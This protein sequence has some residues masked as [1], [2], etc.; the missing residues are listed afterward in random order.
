MGLVLLRDKSGIDAFGEVLFNC[1]Y[2]QLY[3][4]EVCL[5]C[6]ELGRSS[7]YL[8]SFSLSLHLSFGVD[9]GYQDGI[10]TN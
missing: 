1:F 8:Y 6:V 2:F 5:G 10:Q 4:A 3:L 9:F 7:L